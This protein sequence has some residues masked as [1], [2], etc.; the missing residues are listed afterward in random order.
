VFL[1]VENLPV[2]ELEVRLTV[3]FADA[4]TGFPS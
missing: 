3:T 4:V 2:V 1:S